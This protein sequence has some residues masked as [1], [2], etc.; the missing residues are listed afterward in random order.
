MFYLL[1]I[2]HIEVETTSQSDCGVE[3]D[4]GWIYEWQR[5]LNR[6]GGGGTDGLEDK[7]IMCKNK[8]PDNL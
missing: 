1:N 6:G 2:S 7:L 8:I 4:E 3:T 5:W